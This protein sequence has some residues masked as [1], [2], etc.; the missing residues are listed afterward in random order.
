MR[1]PHAGGVPIPPPVQARTRMRLLN[2]ASKRLRGR[3]ARLDI[4]FKGH[5]CYVDAFEEPAPRT[6]AWLA[7]L[8]ESREAYMR[9]T[10][11]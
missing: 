9:I 5:F 2:H 11:G 10:K 3:D 4:R 8:N 1:H 7:A 6:K